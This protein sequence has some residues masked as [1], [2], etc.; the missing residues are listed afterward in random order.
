MG[1]LPVVAVNAV[2]AKCSTII[3]NVRCVPAFVCPMLSVKQLWQDSRV[4]T[5]FR[6]ECA[7]LVPTAS[8]H[9]RLPFTLAADRLYRWN[10]MAPGRKLGEEKGCRQLGS[11]LAA[12]PIHSGH[13]N[14][15]IDVLGAEAAGIAMRRLPSCT[16]DRRARRAEQ[17][18]TPHVCRVR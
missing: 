7:F 4:D 11:A 3:R 15:H 17:V 6:D 5:L 8:G 10:V 2:G 1:D 14:S 12:A 18:S 9:E 13:A 16:A